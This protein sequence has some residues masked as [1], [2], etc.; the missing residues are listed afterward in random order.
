MEIELREREPAKRE[1][2]VHVR[3]EE[4]R[5]NVILTNETFPC[6]I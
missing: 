5:R 1:K 2:R 4:E 6:S 3:G